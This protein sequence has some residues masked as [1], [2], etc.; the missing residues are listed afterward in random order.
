MLRQF[1]AFLASSA[2]A[3]SATSYR[4]A[5]IAPPSWRNAFSRFAPVVKLGVPFLASVS[6]SALKRT[7]ILRAAY[8]V[9]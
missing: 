1:R 6:N 8:L 3:V 2:C 7:R 9:R 4:F 5:S